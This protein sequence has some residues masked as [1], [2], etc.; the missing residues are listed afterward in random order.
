MILVVFMAMALAIMPIPTLGVLAPFLVEEFRLSATELGLA[1]AIFGVV[2]G[3]TA[4]TLGEASDRLGARGALTLLFAISIIAMVTAAVSAAGWVLVLAM[5]IAGLGQGIATP[6]T[7]VAISQLVSVEGWGLATG[8]KEAGVP[9]GAL[10]AGAALPLIAI[11][12]GWRTGFITLAF[13]STFWLLAIRLLLPAMHLQEPTKPRMS[14]KRVP[15]LVNRLAIYAFFIGFGTNAM[16]T[17]LP[18]FA[19]AVLDFEL[20][21]AGLLIAAA[22]AASVMGRIMWSSMTA[23]W[24]LPRMQLMT[25]ACLAM[26]SILLLAASATIASWLAWVGATVFGLSAFAWTSIGSMAVMRTVPGDTTGRATGRV[27]LGFGLGLGFG[28]LAFGLLVDA[29][30]SFLTG[31]VALGFLYLAALLTMATS[32]RAFGIGS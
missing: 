22:G 10:V 21:P 31:L 18:L 6:A 1:S 20:I 11:S 19:E 23:R 2:G 25:I 14:H 29:S 24:N 27:I 15:E 16:L 28:P 3:V 8:I 4:P 30:D 32:R 12:A 5:A 7:N 17:F 26:V 9:A 13:I